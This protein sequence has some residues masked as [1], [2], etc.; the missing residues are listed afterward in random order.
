MNNL[1]L[2]IRDRWPDRPDEPDW[3]LVRKGLANL[4]PVLQ[5]MKYDGL[6]EG[7]EPVIMR[8]MSQA[9]T[10]C[11]LPTGTGKTACFVIP[12][13]C[14]D[15]KAIVFS[16]LVALMRD[17]VKGLHRMGIPAA[18]MSGMQTDGENL[19]A[20]RRWQDGELNFLYVAPERLNNEAFK[21]AMGH[22]N[23]DF[24]VMDECFAPE[25]EIF[26]DKGFVRFDALQDDAKVAQVDPD[27]KTLS[28]VSP[29]KVIRQEYKGDL[30]R[31]HSGQLC[32]LRM[33]PNHELLAFY[34]DRWKKETVSRIKFNHTKRLLVAAKHE[35]GNQTE[36]TAMDRLCIAYQAD[37]S[38]HYV[39][40]DESITAAFSFSKERKINRFLSLLELTGL[41]Y[42]E[43]TN[44]REKLDTGN[45][46]PRRRFLVHKVSGFSKVLSNMF[47]F[48]SMTSEVAAE[49]IREVALWDGSEPYQGCLYYSSII[50]ENV[51][52]VQ[53]VAILAGYKTNLVPQRDERSANYS[54]VWRLFVNT[55]RDWIGT[56]CLSR[57]EE[58]YD[59]LVYCVRVP[60][61][62]IIVRG[63]GKALV[64]GNCHTLS[65]WSDNFRHS[66]CKV[67]DFI[68]E[69]NPKVVA[70]FTATC[71]QQVENDVRRVLGL[72]HARKLTF[73]PRRTNLDLRSDNLVSDISIADKIRETEGSTIV[74][75]ST[76]RKVEELAETLSR[77]LRGKQVRIFHGD[78]SP[79]AK[80]ANQDDFMEGRANIVVATNAFG[81]GVDKP[82]VRA[83][84]HRDIPGTIEALAQEVGRAG[85]DGKYSICITYF[86]QDSLETQNFFLRTGHPPV[87]DIKK[88]YHALK[89]S[90]D[91]SGVCKI[92][93]D[94]I[95]TKANVSKFG[96][97]A[98][99]ETLKGSNVIVRD[100]VDK[101]ICKL[102]ETDADVPSDN[103]RYHDY[104]RVVD[105]LGIPND[106][107]FY[108]FDL[109]EFADTVGVGY[110]TVRGW[111][112]R[113]AES[114][115]IRFCDPYVGAETRIIGDLS[116]VDF[117]RLALKRD[118]AYRK[119]DDVLKYVNLPDSE[120][121]EFIETYFRVH[122]S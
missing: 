14:M 119:L 68:R 88:V 51:D 11:I 111:F 1:E 6:R 45:R 98:I 95:S 107:G 52:F 117:D 77:N 65:Q 110:S 43:V 33:T 23:P 90:A 24:V 94:E 57:T 13:L 64:V 49:F 20:A 66:Y 78:L 74:Y 32:D 121:H 70:A 108:E 40:P 41:S 105:S 59:G 29:D 26:T 47:D 76:R 122:E 17:Q 80:R 50:K 18:A 103:E 113:W 82:D 69:Y 34:G 81:M 92:T 46:I 106:E 89:L 38:S 58:S 112:K 56:Q 72:A 118:D 93:A 60:H 4:A 2:S 71:P 54:T 83:V 63:S 67:G 30:I 48:A 115:F 15:W 53:A 86:S 27:T 5:R 3:E 116:L 101:K 62:N 120:K 21:T 99:F 37:G 25:V 55:E 75:C 91:R 10:I 87:G 36:L 12:T 100:Q 109:N 16:P 61:G 42:S 22:V 28:F 85:R 102:R 44:E 84:I 79:G 39:H 104:M 9:D 73:Y 31:L 97:R 96:M 7:Q 114:G 8:I 35:A 19:D